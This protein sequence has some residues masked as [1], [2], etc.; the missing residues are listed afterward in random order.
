[1][2]A[3]LNWGPEEKIKMTERSGLSLPGLPPGITLTSTEHYDDIWRIDYEWELSP[4]D[5]I[6]FMVSAEQ[7][8]GLV[9]QAEEAAAGTGQKFSLSEA[10]RTAADAL[11]VLQ[12]RDTI[13]A[14]PRL[15]PW[16]K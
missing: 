2:R 4:A 8:D 1:V 16:R 14:D 6:T 7:V 5:S 13:A 15:S 11:V 9:K 12:I 3:S 10:R